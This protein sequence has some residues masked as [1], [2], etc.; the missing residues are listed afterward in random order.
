MLQFNMKGYERIVVIG[1][2][3]SGKTTMAC[4]I[5]KRLAVPHV[6][7]DSLHWEANWTEAKVED[8][9]ERVRSAVAGDA[10]VVCGNYSAVRSLVWPRAE[11]VVWLDYS[12]QVIMS[13]LLRRTLRRAFTREELWNGNKESLRTAF[14][15]RDSILLWALTTYKTRRKESPLLFAL[16]EHS[17]LRVVHLRSPRQADA[18]LRRLKRQTHER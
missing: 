14:F 9:C 18:W 10:W 12:F 5:A 4:N 2:S 3:G 8:F 13:R 16:P 7:L 15:S 1:T 6:E 17:H 11:M